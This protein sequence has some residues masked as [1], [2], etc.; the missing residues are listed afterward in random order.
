MSYRSTVTFLIIHVIHLII[1]EFRGNAETRCTILRNEQR[2]FHGF[3]G[4]FF[5]LLRDRGIDFLIKELFDECATRFEMTIGQTHNFPSP[6]LFNIEYQIS[7]NIAKITLNLIL[8]GCKSIFVLA[9]F[10]IESDGF[11]Q[12]KK[13]NGK[14]EKKKKHEE[15]MRLSIHFFFSLPNKRNGRPTGDR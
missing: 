11:I 6:S 2:Y 12:I 13:R 8:V 7:N 5:E 14:N 10:Y 4:I 9:N 3:A 15:R 1:H